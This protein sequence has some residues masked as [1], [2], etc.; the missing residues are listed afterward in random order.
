MD[1]RPRGLHLRGE[2]P[3]EFVRVLTELLRLRAQIAQRFEVGFGVAVRHI[4]RL[5]HIRRFATAVADEDGSGLRAQRSGS[6]LKAQG[7]SKTIEQV[8]E[9][10][11]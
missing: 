11:A 1:G 8:R 6:R 7:S 4:P 9:D 2:A 5:S 10:L 3:A